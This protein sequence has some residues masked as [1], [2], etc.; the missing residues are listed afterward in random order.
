MNV[1]EAVEKGMLRK[2]KADRNLIEKELQ[3]ARYDLKK[4]EQNL[5]EDDIKWST[6]QSYYAMFH[7]ARALLFKDDYR[8]K[9]HAG[10]KIFL[11]E[12]VSEGRLESMYLDDFRAAANARESADYHYSYSSETAKMLL[13]S[14]KEFVAK[15]SKMVK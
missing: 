1:K 9:S 5:K 11:E 2:E 13:N 12:M 15:A 7:A 10:L 3:E 8:E 6:V 4:A 14:A